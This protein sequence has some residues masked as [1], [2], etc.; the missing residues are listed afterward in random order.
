[1]SPGTRPHAACV[2]TRQFPIGIL[3]CL[4][5]CGTQGA[6][7]S[8]SS[9]TLTPEW[10]AEADT[11]VVGYR[12]LA[13]V[14]DQI[15]VLSR[16]APFLRRY[17]ERGQLLGS[18]VL[19]G[20]GPDEVRLPNWIVAPPEATPAAQTAY[21]VHRMREL[22]PL[23]STGQVRGRKIAFRPGGGD[24][25]MKVYALSY[26]QPRLIRAATHSRLLVQQ[27]RRVMVQ[28][29]A[30]VGDAL[31][32]VVDTS[33]VVT[34]TIA[35]LSSLTPPLAG[36]RVTTFV[37]VPLWAVCHSELVA[38]FSPVTLEVSWRS[39]A[40]R[41]KWRVTADLATRRVSGSDRSRYAR[42]A[43]AEEARRP[44]G[45]LDQLMSML[46]TVIVQME[47]S[48]SK[49]TPPAVSL[50]C[51]VDGTAWL[52]G[53]DTSDDPRGYGRL[54]YGISPAGRSSQ[55]SMPRGFQPIAVR[56]HR[57][58]GWLTDEDGVQRIARVAAR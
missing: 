1:M 11:S 28:S 3:A 33:G 14:G 9:I 35:D 46:A 18:S 42:A 27:Q 50:L 34:D 49:T 7:P 29:T 26:G 4:T 56:E 55:A 12:D 32:L 53:F 51:D 24:A 52:Q 48:F 30:D 19:M 38:V 31:L 25:I 2:T 15:W 5:A 54:W 47:P 22:A 8:N 40:G 45:R 41:I 43:L 58:V 13:L 37:P 39:T 16:S 17:S 10:V 23:D 20:D 57:F 21:L 44:G 6:S 36:P